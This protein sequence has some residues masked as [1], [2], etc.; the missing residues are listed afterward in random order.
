MF[1][2]WIVDLL[3]GFPSMVFRS[4]LSLTNLI[5]LIDFD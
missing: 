2:S 3:F 4:Q 5:E 1:L